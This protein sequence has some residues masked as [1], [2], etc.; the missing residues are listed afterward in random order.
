MVSLSA[1][2]PASLAATGAA[3]VAFAAGGVA[4]VDQKLAAEAEDRRPIGLEVIDDRPRC[5]REVRL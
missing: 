5:P 1:L 4:G 3:L 2:I